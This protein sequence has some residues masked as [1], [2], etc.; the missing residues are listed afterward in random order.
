LIRKRADVNAADRKG[1]TPLCEASYDGREDI[2]AIVLAEGA[3]V[4]ARITQADVSGATAVMLAALNGH[5]GVVKLLLRH[6][7]DVNARDRMGQSAL[8]KAILYGH[9]EVA[10]LIRA[11]GGK[12]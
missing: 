4:N 12:E 11:A 10:E 3:R 2:A 6:G 1:W 5:A 9:D 7:A 8:T